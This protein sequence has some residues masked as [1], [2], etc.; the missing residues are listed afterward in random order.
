MIGLSDI[1]GVVM[2]KAVVDLTGSK[3]LYDMHHRFAAALEFPDYYGENFSAFWDCLSVDC[4][5][6]FVT[7]IGVKAL[8]AELK[9]Y[10][11]KFIELLERNKQHWAHGDP[12]FDYKIVG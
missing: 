9:P 8:S 4:D 3:S 1:G 12:P 11:E 5:V 7:V 2:K 6:D 10:G